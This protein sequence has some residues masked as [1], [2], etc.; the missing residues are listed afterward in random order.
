MSELAEQLREARETNG[1]FQREAGRRCGISKTSIVY[2]EQG[3][4]IPGRDSLCKLA[5]VYGLSEDYLMRMRERALVERKLD[6]QRSRTKRFH[7]NNIIRGRGTKNIK[8]RVLS[9]RVDGTLLVERV[10]RPPRKSIN[11][12]EFYQVVSNA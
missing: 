2:Y 6:K 9:V 12:P 1:W 3:R 11:R 5:R 8:W 10:I 4:A 7:K